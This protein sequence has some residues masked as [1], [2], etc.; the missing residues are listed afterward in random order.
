MKTDTWSGTRALIRSVLAGKGVLVRVILVTLVESLAAF[1]V[2]L[3]FANMLEVQNF[4]SVAIYILLF[5]CQWSAARL[6]WVVMKS[7]STR[8]LQ[9]LEKEVLSSIQKSSPDYL[10]NVAIRE[11]KLHSSQLWQLTNVIGSDILY[12][13]NNLF[14]ITFNLL[15]IGIA[16]GQKYLTATLIGAAICILFQFPMLWLNKR[17]ALKEKQHDAAFNNHFDSIIGSLFLLQE[18]NQISWKAEQTHQELKKI[19][20]LYARTEPLRGIATIA[21]L[22]APVAGMLF[23][24]LSWATSDGMAPEALATLHGYILTVVPAINAATQVFMRIAEN[25]G[26]LRHLG[27]ILQAPKR[28][29]GKE[30]IRGVIRI[31][32]QGSLKIGEELLLKIPKL[33]FKE[34][35]FYVIVGPS[36]AGKSLF[37]KLV[38]RRIDGTGDFRFS[39][40]YSIHSAG[41]VIEALN[42]TL[43]SFYR[44]IYYVPQSAEWIDGLREG[45]YSL[46]TAIESIAL[47]ILEEGRIPRK[48]EPFVKRA[49]EIVEL[50]EELCQKNVSQL[51][52][53]EKIRVSIARALLGC[54]LNP[55]SVLLLDESLS[56]LPKE[57]GSKIIRK[58]RLLQKR[59]GFITLMV[60]HSDD[61]NPASANCLVIEK[62]VIE[63]GKIWTLRLNPFSRYNQLRGFKFP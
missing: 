42:S 27:M 55:G 57:L 58:I 29:E 2:P 56:Q 52:G 19:E 34:G 15:G 4:T 25:A 48:Y 22:V 23:V 10:D 5:S 39:G 21:S 61:V 26:M 38:S 50:D 40:T 18:N 41:K 33:E 36:G 53:G 16:F 43:S 6:F 3:A 59:F 32:L 46:A 30:I 14:I 17:I 63:K 24:F 49:A 35:E 31:I 47:G 45:A 12:V 62:G 1:L 20:R 44:Y 51:S 54:M 13:A 11:A 8:M 60:S 28:P 9:W 37:L 7:Q